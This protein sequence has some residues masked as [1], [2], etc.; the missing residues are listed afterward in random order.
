MHKNSYVAAKEFESDNEERE[1]NAF[2]GRFLIPDDGLRA[3]WNE[4]RGLHWIDAVLRVK[5]EYKV[6]CLAILF[7]L[8]ELYP[9][10]RERQLEKD[11][12]VQYKARFGHDL[13]DHYE[14]EALSPSD[15]VESRFL[16]LVRRALESEAIT[17]ERAAEMLDIS[18]DEMGIRAAEWRDG[19]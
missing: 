13:K 18:L 14:P 6:S 19:I 10:L 11:F 8:K 4:L 3:A 5:K 2:A 1:A 16:G 7:R 17:M 12:A 9:A 15:L